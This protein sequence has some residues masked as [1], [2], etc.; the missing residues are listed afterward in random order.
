MDVIIKEKMS[1]QFVISAG[2]TI[3]Q[4]VAKKK[5]RNYMA[6][7]GHIVDSFNV[8]QVGSGATP[9]KVDVNCFTNIWDLRGMRNKE[10]NEILKD[11]PDIPDVDL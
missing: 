10:A 9:W 3:D 7:R 8:V 6:R 5:I 11:R 1:F 2:I 4:Q